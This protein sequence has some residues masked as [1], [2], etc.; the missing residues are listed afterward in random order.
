[1]PAHL[2]ALALLVGALIGSALFCLLMAVAYA[3]RSLT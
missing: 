3:V 2:K 1:M